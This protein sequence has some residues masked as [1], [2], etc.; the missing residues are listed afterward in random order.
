ME[1]FVLAGIALLTLMTVV[2]AW[3]DNLALQL[4]VTALAV[5]VSPRPRRWSWWR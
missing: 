3:G 2:I 1:F 5:L 4:L